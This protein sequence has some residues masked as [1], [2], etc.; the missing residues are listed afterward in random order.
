M[1]VL[2]DIHDGFF[3]GL[4]RSE[5]KQIRLFLRTD[6]GLCST[7]VLRDVERLNVSNFREGNIVFDVSLVEPSMVTA[8]HIEQLY[9]CQP[10]DAA[11]VHRFLTSVKQK[12]LSVLEVNP[13]YGAECVA[14]F[15]TLEILPSHVLPP[16]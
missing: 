6:A 2:P 11:L 10:N 7:I 1:D 4:W 9:G 13:S 3:D 16:A 5:D 8:E 14:L 12:G 15:K